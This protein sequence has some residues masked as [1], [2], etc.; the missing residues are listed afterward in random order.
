MFKAQSESIKVQKMYLFSHQEITLAPRSTDSTDKNISEATRSNATTV[1]TTCRPRNR[2]SGSRTRKRSWRW[3][4]R[5]TLLATRSRHVSGSCSLAFM[6]DPYMCTINIFPSLFFFLLIAISSYLHFVLGIM[7][8]ND[9]CISITKLNSENHFHFGIQKT[10]I[11]L[12]LIGYTFE[13]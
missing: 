2:G 8:N 7:S 9:P 11:Y 13:I 6:S 12:L 4:R 10:C 1:K 5:A 3:K